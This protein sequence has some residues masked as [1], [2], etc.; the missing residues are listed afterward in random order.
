M[1]KIGVPAASIKDR[2]VCKRTPCSCDHPYQ[3]RRYGKGVR[4]H[5]RT[6]DS[7]RCTVCGKKK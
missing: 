3:D 2:P 4:I 5:N 1:A 6:T 7:Y